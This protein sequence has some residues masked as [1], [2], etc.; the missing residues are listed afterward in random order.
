MAAKLTID[1]QK[2]FA[3]MQNLPAMAEKAKGLPIPPSVRGAMPAVSM[4]GEIL[5]QL[6]VD[7][8]ETGLNVPGIDTG[9]LGAGKMRYLRQRE[10]FSDAHVAASIRKILQSNIPEVEAGIQRIGEAIDF[11]LSIQSPGVNLT[12]MVQPSDKQLRGAVDTVL[13][14]PGA[15]SEVVSD[16]LGDMLYYTLRITAAPKMA[17]SAPGATQEGEVD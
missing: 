6:I 8:D 4:F 3:L 17:K 11:T 2:A 14:T 12:G 16:K 5:Q 7:D 1:L 13:V 10:S 15:L 9:K